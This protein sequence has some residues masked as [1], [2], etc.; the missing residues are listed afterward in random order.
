M[1]RIYANRIWAGDYDFNSTNKSYIKLKPQVI[2]IM[3][4]DVA[5]GKHTKE[6]FEEV[7]GLPY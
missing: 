4:G 5:D 2:E 6:E 1:A 3:R 7:T